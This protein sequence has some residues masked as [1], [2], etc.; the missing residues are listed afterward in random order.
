[1]AESR[2]DRTTLRWPPEMQ[3]AILARAKMRM[4]SVSAEVRELLT[5]ARNNIQPDQLVSVPSYREQKST[6]ICLTPRLHHWLHSRANYND[7][8]V[9]VELVSL[10]AYA[11]ELV[12]ERDL[13]LLVQS[14]DKGQA[15]PALG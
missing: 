5:F 11:L 12:M 1:M 2:T 8:S 13:A 6:S 3:S 10:L 4:R 7:R 14:L 9:Q 15:E